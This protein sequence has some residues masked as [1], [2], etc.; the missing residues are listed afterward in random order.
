MR[1]MPNRACV[2]CLM[3]SLSVSGCHV[4]APA[5]Q[6]P[7]DR[8]GTGVELIQ[9]DIPGQTTTF[10]HS[11]RWENG[12]EV[13]VGAPE[14]YEP[15]EPLPDENAGIPVAVAVEVRNH[16]GSNYNPLHLFLSAASGGEEASHFDIGAR[17]RFRAPLTTVPNGHSI[18]FEMAFIMTDAT[19]AVVDV[20]PGMPGYRTATFTH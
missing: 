8:Y 20:I 7:T 18:R 5:R 15:T 19:Q 3:I 2:L 14:P 9:L 4:L 13:V 11:A 12:L 16:T 1:A 17:G 6:E 10:G